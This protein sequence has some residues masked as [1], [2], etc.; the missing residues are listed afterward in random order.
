[1]KSENISI[2]KYLVLKRIL[3]ILLS[4]IALPIISIIIIVA[5]LFIK[6]DTNGPV[7]FTQ[8]RAGIN[9]KPF[10]IIKLRSMIVDAE[11]DTGSVWAEKNDV[12]IT[13]VGKILRKF[14]I[15]ELPQFINV[16]AGDMSIIG[17]RPEKVDLT[18]EFN[19]LYPGFKNRLQVKPGITGL[20]QING[21]YDVMPA[22]KMKFDLE[23]IENV[24]LLMDIKIIIRTVVVIFTGE[25]SR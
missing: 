10:T 22:E 17:P 13:K 7:F 4:I 16:I 15:D 12:R 11:K 24:S 5:S 1:M 8:I 9:G 21:G 14:R 19:I 20:A 18:E 6:L 23:Y 3:D 2:K 25:G